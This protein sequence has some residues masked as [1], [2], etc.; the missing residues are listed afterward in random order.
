MSPAPSALIEFDADTHT[1]RAEGRVI[2][3]VTQVLEAAGISDF[4]GVPA[5]ILTRAQSRGT[6]VHQAAWYDDQADLDESTLDPAIR[7]YLEAWRR[8]R[9]D[10][11]VAVKL[12]EERI[13]CPMGYAGTF[14]R[15]V[16]MPKFGEAMLD[17]KTGEETASWPIQLAA[18]TKGFF[19]RLAPKCR[20][21][22]VKL[23]KDGSY[24][25]CWYEMKDMAR[26]WNVFAGA[27]VVYKYRKENGLI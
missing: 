15:L 23:R 5:D 2:P 27:L 20:R 16:D 11:H 13:Y 19:G 7:G 10:N 8:F 18:Y 21:G 24:Q 9:A 26:D 17:L 4:S 12:I 3:S 22:A 14:D 1:Y 6:A 25:L